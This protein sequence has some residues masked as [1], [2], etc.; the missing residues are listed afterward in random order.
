[1]NLPKILH[2]SVIFLFFVVSTSLIYSQEVQQENTNTDS[3]TEVHGVIVCINE[4]IAKLR[5]SKPMCDKYGHIYGLKTSDGMIWSFMINPIG[6]DLRE[7]KSHFGKEVRVWGRL[8]YKAKIIEVKNFK[9]LEENE[10][11]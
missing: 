9:I 7:N 11:K 8:F 3:L 10:K 1:M 2:V 4:E 6:K 5:H